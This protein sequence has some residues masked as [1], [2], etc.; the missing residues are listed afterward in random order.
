MR[1]ARLRHGFFIAV[2]VLVAACATGPLTGDDAAVLYDQMTDADIER[3]VAAL[4]DSLTNNLPGAATA[5]ENPNTGNSG[6]VVAGSVFVTDQGVFCRDYDENVL[7]A[8]LAGVTSN[9]ACRD[10]AGVWQW[11]N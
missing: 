9:T 3:A 5:W 11:V 6:S 10:D 2:A 4:Q 8:G 7:V 1:I